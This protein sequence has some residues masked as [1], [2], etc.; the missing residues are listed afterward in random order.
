MDAGFETALHQVNSEAPATK[1]TPEQGGKQNVDLSH[2]TQESL[3]A[4]SVH[5]LKEIAKGAHVSIAECVEK[6][7]IVNKLLTTQTQ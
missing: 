3:S 5:E 7:E 2:E 4:K 1:K 6:S